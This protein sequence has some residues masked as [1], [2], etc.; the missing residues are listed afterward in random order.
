M[1]GDTPFPESEVKVSNRR[2]TVKAK[3]SPVPQS[4][5]ALTDRQLNVH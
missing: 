2:V 1:S 4:L 3:N 5:A